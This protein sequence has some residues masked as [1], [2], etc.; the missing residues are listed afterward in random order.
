MLGI[1]NHKRD[2]NRNHN[3][4]SHPLGWLSLKKKKI[5]TVG[6]DVE[7]LELYTVGGILK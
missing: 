1:S 3:E 6:R 4:R 2:A 5:T 7:K